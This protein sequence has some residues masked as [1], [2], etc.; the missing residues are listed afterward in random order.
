[1]DNSAKKAVHQLCKQLGEPQTGVEAHLLRPAEDVCIIRQVA[2][3]LLVYVTAY[4]D[5]DCESEVWVQ[6]GTAIL[7]REVEDSDG[8]F[9]ELRQLISEVLAGHLSEHF[10]PSGD[11]DAESIGYSVVSGGDVLFSGGDALTGGDFTVS[12]RGHFR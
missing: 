1:M 12:V 5:Q 2:S 7:I 3:G 11:G 10:R 8:H 4:D 6:A 9:S